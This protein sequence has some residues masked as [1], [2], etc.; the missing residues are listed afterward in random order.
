MRNVIVV[1]VILSLVLPVS[2][3]LL[4]KNIYV[5]ITPGKEKTTIDNYYLFEYNAFYLSDLATDLPEYRLVIL[6]QERRNVVNST[7]NK[8]NFSTAPYSP[9]AFS[10]AV[11]YKD[12]LV[13]EKLI[14]LC[15]YNQICEPCKERGCELAENSLSCSDCPSG[16]SDVFC[17]LNRDNICDPDCNGID[18]DCGQCSETICAYDE[19]KFEGQVA[20]IPA[21][22]G[23]QFEP[24]Y[25][26]E[27]PSPGAY[28]LYGII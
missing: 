11:Y 16:S 24:S 8:L 7:F 12:K 25:I 22:P 19:A 1:L 26:E 5:K 14:S 17:D 4:S 9:E 13:A 2:E 3:A 23:L 28:T 27:P 15:S 6:D 18:A 20:D 10:L 21:T